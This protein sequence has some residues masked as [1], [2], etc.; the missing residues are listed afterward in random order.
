MANSIPT[1]A[2]DDTGLE[3]LYGL[4]DAIIQ[5]VLAA[6][7]AGDGAAV[8]WLVS[9]LHPTDVTDLFEC[10][11]TAQRNALEKLLGDDLD[12]DVVTYLNASLRHDH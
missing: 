8:G 7:G 6:V 2:F 10:L 12:P 5:G 11:L 3:G 9:A 4:T 1:P